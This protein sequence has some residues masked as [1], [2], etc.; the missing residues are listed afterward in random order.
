M[1]L[2]EIVQI[3][4]LAPI[5]GADR[6]EKAKVLGWHVVVQKGLHKIGD[7]VIFIFPDTLVPKKFLDPSCVKDEK[8]RL[9][10]I[11]LRGQYSAGLILPLSDFQNSLGE[12]SLGQDVGEL[13][14]VEKYEKV[15]PPQL[16][17][18]IKGNFP[19]IISK[20]DEDNYKSNP[21]AIAELFSDDRF[22]GI[23]L[24][25]SVKYD[26]TSATFIFD[27]NGDQFKV[28]S[29]NLELRED[30]S[31]LYWK[32]AK[33]LD[34]Q[35][36]TSSDGKHYA[37]Q[38]EICG[39]GI[40]GNNMKLNKIEFYVFLIKDLDRNEWLS[41][42]ETVKFCAE[43]GLNTAREISRF[44]IDT[45]PSLNSLQELS[46]NLKYDSGSDAE[47]FVLRPV[48]PISSE[49]LNKSWWSVKFISEK[50][51]SKH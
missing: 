24:Y 1:K 38:G 43:N 14:G 22:K 44:N 7:N 19:S 10:T 16:A 3:E 23:E 27:P 21:K 25:L 36:V 47:G 18:T 11:R 8:V 42:D 50:Y 40:N 34:I 30:D 39:P 26:G 12:L 29:R 5:E 45:L 35:K 31:N 2:T 13:I 9:K 20:T 33:D 46:N 28:C 17:G 37:I 32:V 49:K 51:D 4:E 41:W 6:I 15:I 48:I